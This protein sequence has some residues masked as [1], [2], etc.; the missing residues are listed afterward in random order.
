M[1][2]ALRR[3]LESVVE[4]TPMPFGEFGKFTTQYERFVARL[5]ALEDAFNNL[6]KKPNMLCKNCEQKCERCVEPIDEFDVDVFCKNMEKISSIQPMTYTQ[7]I[8]IVKKNW[9]ALRVKQKP[10]EDGYS[11]SIVKT[12]FGE[13]HWDNP[14]LVWVYL[15]NNEEGY[16]ASQTQLGVT[17]DGRVLYEY[18]SHCSCDGYE[19]SHGGDGCPMPDDTTKTYRL[20]EIPNEWKVVVAQNVEKML[21]YLKL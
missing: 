8:K 19:D 13:S 6:K 1:V 20:K 9:D 15:T 21:K 5:E 17:R 2:R 11:R 4:I 16:E 3:E 14:D 7:A 10:K 12:P 18:Q